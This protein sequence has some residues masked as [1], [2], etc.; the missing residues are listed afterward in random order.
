MGTKL[1]FLKE[2]G[3]LLD[4]TE[5]YCGSKEACWVQVGFQIRGEKKTQ[6]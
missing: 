3:S 4:K 2:Q 1:V 6:L 5:I